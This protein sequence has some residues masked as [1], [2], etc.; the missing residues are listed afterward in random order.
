MR[1]LAKTRVGATGYTRQIPLYLMWGFME[2]RD[3][4]LK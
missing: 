2:V 1:T 4:P 3:Q